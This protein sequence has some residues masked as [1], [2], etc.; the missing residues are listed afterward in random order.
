MHTDNLHS[1]KDDM[2]AFITGL[3]LRR[4]IGHVTEDIPQV[5]VENNGSDSWKDFVE[6]A[7]ASGAAFLTMSEMVLEKEEV[8]SLLE[9]M[10]DQDFPEQEALLED[11]RKLLRHAGK[12]GYLQLGFP[13]QGIM[14]LFEAR[15]DWYVLFQ[16]M[17]ES[18]TAFDELMMGGHGCDC[19]E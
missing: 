6:N 15:T 14:F 16:G 8:L 13:Y 19:D 4:I 2:V 12:I 17:V 3:G 11:T 18:V 7:K 1:L 9:D 5:V 10:H